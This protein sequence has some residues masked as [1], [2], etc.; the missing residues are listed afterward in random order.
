M[1]SSSPLS[2]ARRDAG[3]SAAPTT[4]ALDHNFPEP[5]LNTLETFMVDIRLVP[6]RRID[7]RLPD[8]DDRQLVIALHQ[9]GYEGLVTNNYKMLKNPTELAA[10]LKTNLT[11]F[12][13]EG[14]GHDPLRATGAVLLDLPS[15]ARK[16]ASQPGVFWLR[17]RN[18]QLMDPW[19][20]FRNAAE[21]QQRSSAE[22]Y[23]E[24]AVSEEELHRQVLGV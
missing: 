12:A 8:L 6:I 11:V 22:L 9:L 19:E 5:I 4:L 10:I 24:V 15:A 17:P 2:V 14:V 20:L 21:H 18:P 1:S 23:Q 7:Q 3:V 16:M 13:I